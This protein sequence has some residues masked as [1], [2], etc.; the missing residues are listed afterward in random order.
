MKR[1]NSQQAKSFPG[2]IVSKYGSC[3]KPFFYRSAPRLVGLMENQL[4][5]M[6]G[7]YDTLAD[8][9][10]E[11]TVRPESLDKFLDQNGGVMISAL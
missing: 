9:M 5:K 4:K 11:S 6:Q 3:V 7:L 8:Q 2:Q 1:I 10:S